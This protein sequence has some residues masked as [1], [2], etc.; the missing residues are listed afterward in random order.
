[1]TIQEA[2]ER[3]CELLDRQL[4]SGQI[5]KE[6]HLRLTRELRL[7]LQDQLREERDDVSSM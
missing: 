2:Y 4:E 6:E 7:D 5:S 1:M 3:E